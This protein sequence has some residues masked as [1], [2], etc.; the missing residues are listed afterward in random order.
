MKTGDASR[1][2]T[3]ETLFYMASITK[4]FIATA[5]MQLWEEGRIGLDAPVEK[6]VPTSV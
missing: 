4:P 6:Y 1:P 2:V 3:P 5:V